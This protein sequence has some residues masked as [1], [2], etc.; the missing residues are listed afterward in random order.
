M[1]L[2]I[3]YPAWIYEKSGKKQQ[4]PIPYSRIEDENFVEM[5]CVEICTDSETEFVPKIMH[6]EYFENPDE[7]MRLA[8]AWS[9]HYKFEEKVRVEMGYLTHR[10]PNHVILRQVW[11]P[12]SKLEIKLS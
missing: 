4:Q 2:G 7:A 5:W 6:T 10:K 12:R 8:K 1:I 3:G 11:A 9:E